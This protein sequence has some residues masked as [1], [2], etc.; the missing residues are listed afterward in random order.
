MWSAAADAQQPAAA[1]QCSGVW[2]TLLR[3]LTASLVLH[4]F[5]PDH[6][7]INLGIGV[8]ILCSGVCLHVQQSEDI[9]KGF[10]IRG[11]RVPCSG[12]TL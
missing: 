7:G 5:P 12:P 3:S 8:Y 2:P 6:R 1:A 11:F 4:V 10:D 9:H